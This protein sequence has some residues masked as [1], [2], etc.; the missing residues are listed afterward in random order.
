LWDRAKAFTGK[1]VQIAVDLDGDHQVTMD[2][3]G[4][5]FDDVFIRNNFIERL[6]INGSNYSDKPVRRISIALRTDTIAAVIVSIS[7][8]RQRSSVERGEIENILQA[9]RV[10][11]SKIYIWGR[12]SYFVVGVISG[13]IAAS[14]GD[15]ISTHLGMEDTLRSSIVMFVPFAVVLGFLS[16]FLQG[17]LFPACVFEHGKSAGIGKR[18]EY[19]R[20]I[21]GVGVILAFVVAIASGVFLEWTK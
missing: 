10:W 17:R 3:I 6:S 5:F 1:D 14:V 16:S 7:G 9:R 20:N 11:Y 13:M 21:V 8:D 19:W 2:D 12:A 4:A 18:A 15:V